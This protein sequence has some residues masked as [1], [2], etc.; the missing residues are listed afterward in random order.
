MAANSIGRVRFV[1]VDCQYRHHEIEIDG[2]LFSEPHFSTGRFRRDDSK[3][4]KRERVLR[5]FLNTP[6][7]R[8]SKLKMNEIFK[9]ST[10]KDIKNEYVILH[11]RIAPPTTHYH[12]LVPLIKQTICLPCCAEEMIG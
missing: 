9:G 3:M 8:W 6:D 1:G 11:S 4:P 5:R 7:S 2:G 12:A 10:D